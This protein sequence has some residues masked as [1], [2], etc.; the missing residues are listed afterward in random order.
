MTLDELI[1]K[2]TEIRDEHGG[3]P[4]VTRWNT[5]CC[6]GDWEVDVTDVEFD[7]GVLIS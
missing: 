4:L 1:A 7:G 5:C 2:L 3:S 6:Y